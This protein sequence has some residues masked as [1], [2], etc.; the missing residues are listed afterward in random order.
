[1]TPRRG[2]PRPRAVPGRRAALGALGRGALAA[3]LGVPSA[4]RAV[5]VAGLEIGDTVRVA[6]RTLP[7]RGAGVRTR[8]LVK[9]YVA[10]LYTDDAT[11]AGPELAAA[12]APMAVRIAIRSDLVTRERMVEALYEGFG[13]STGGNLAPVRDGID[14]ALAVMP[15]RLGAG[16]RIDLVYV[17]GTGTAVLR[18]GRRLAVVEGLAFKE[19]LF[20]I[21]LSDDPVQLQMKRDLLGE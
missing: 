12:D 19:A 6:G 9:L 16:D 14:T 21:W 3:S 10:A 5:T 20:G 13:K 2:R 17:P 4:A 7:L 8:F 15:E 11:A 1:M 18:E